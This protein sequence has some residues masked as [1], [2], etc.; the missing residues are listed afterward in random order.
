MEFFIRPI[1]SITLIEK[2]SKKK[3]SLNEKNFNLHFTFL[4]SHLYSHRV[5]LK[6]GEQFS[7][8]LKETE[9]TSDYIIYNRR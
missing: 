5:I 8:D 7:G 1:E 6:S 4:T 2:N 3:I 9:G